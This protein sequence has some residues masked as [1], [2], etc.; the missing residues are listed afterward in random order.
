MHVTLQSRLSPSLLYLGWLIYKNLPPTRFFAL[1]RWLLRWG[2]VE[3]A[4]DVRIVSSVRI[5]FNGS[6][7]I[8]RSTWVGH[9]ALFIGGSDSVIQIGNCCDIGPRVSFIAG[10]HEIDPNG[11]HAAGVP[12]SE[13]I[14]IGDGVWLC[15]S[16]TI[17]GDT[18]LGENCVVAA[19]A[20]V[21]G[22]FPA[23]SLIGG[24]PA[25]LIRRL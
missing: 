10:T 7:S 5:A 25:R 24:V 21:R 8:G 12:L 14:S 13:S 4:E 22:S 3:I 9:D 19:G 1:K 23:K 11:A 18:V 20:V 6:L 17:L 16:V 2:G 15:A